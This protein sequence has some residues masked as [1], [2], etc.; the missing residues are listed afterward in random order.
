M[1]HLGPDFHHRALLETLAVLDQLGVERAVWWGHS[2]GAV[3]AALAGI[4]HPDR[5]SGVILEALHLYGD[6]PGSRSFFQK[7]AYEPDSFGPTL[8][9][10]LAADHGEDRWRRVLEQDGMA[11]LDIAARSESRGVLYDGRLGELGA[12]TMLV[13]GGRD[14]RGEPGEW[15]AIR[16]ALPHATTAYYPS[17]GHSP[18][19]EP[20][21]ADEVASAALRFVTSLGGTPI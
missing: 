1:A 18:H 5:C 10:R 12:P 16:E 3:I 9:A 11:W 15:E 14:P 4:H 2:D 6:K 7:M 19:S 21:T 17:A 20:D 8:T 13:Y